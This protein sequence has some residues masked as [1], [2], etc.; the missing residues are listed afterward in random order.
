MLYNALKGYNVTILAYGQTSS[1]KTHTISGTNECPGLIVLTANSL[2][3]NLKYLVTPEG[4]NSMPAPHNNEV[5]FTERRT[6]VTISYLEIYN[7]NVNDL[8]DG[9]KRNLEVRENKSGDVIV[10]GLTHKIVTC[11]EEFMECLRDGELVRIFAETK[12]NVNSSRSHTVF[13]IQ[14][15]IVDINTETGRRSIRTS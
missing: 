11:Q 13:R 9:S 6:H 12:A 2:F 1:G 4:I 15:E 3:K 5:N 14:V 10:E 8:L 7:E